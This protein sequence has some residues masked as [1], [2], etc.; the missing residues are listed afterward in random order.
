MVS[1]FI[2]Q[3]YSAITSFNWEHLYRPY[4]LW[5]IRY[6]NMKIKSNFFRSHGLAYHNIL[7]TKTTPSKVDG[8]SVSEAVGECCPAEISGNGKCTKSWSTKS[9]SVSICDAQCSVSNQMCNMA[10]E[11]SPLICGL[12]FCTSD[13]STWKLSFQ[14]SFWLRIGA[15]SYVAWLRISVSAIIT[16]AL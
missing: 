15:L 11:P 10:R 8:Q 14:S 9:D 2:S 6:Q 4:F 12:R 16:D 13:F 7:I 5:G 1:A 3:P